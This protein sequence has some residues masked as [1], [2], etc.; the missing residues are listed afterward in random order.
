MQK[1]PTPIIESLPCPLL[2]S[3]AIK[4]SSVKIQKPTPVTTLEGTSVAPRQRPKG[5]GAAAG[6]ISLSGQIIGQISGQGNQ[7]QSQT[8]LGNSIAYSSVNPQIPPMNPPQAFLSQNIQTI[9]TNQQQPLQLSGQSSFAQVSPHISSPNQ[10]IPFG[11]SQGQPS[12]FGQ[13]QSPMISHSPL[14]HQSPVTI[15]D[16]NPYYFDSRSNS[17]TVND[18]NL[19][20]LFPSFGKLILQVTLLTNVNL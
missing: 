5:Q 11:Q 2:E 17:T 6:P 14:P 3:E 19:D 7:L 8:S 12:P 20:V 4:R 9:Q 13:S 10:P 1:V 16:K 15:Q 18:E